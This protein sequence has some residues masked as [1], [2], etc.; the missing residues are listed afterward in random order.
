MNN[1]QRLQLIRERLTAALTPSHLD[2]EDESQRH[3]GHAGAETGM[4][5]FA[6]SIQSPLFD[7]K[8]PVQCHRL[9]YDALGSLMQT[10]IHALRISIQ[11]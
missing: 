6:V 10:E 11:K 7:G 2:V 8:S 4:G 9:V 1:E 5:H 3:A